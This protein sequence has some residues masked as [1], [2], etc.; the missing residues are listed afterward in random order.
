MT[1]ISPRRREEVVGGPGPGLALDR[2]GYLA[3][4]ARLTPLVQPKPVC[5]EYSPPPPGWPSSSQLYFS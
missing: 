5:T 3:S 4:K 1:E 2:S